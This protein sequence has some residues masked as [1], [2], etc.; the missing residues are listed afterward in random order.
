MYVM[1]NILNN[2]TRCFCSFIF[3]TYL[4]MNNQRCGWTPL[5]GMTLGWRV[6][7]TVVSGGTGASPLAFS[8]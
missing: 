4:R 1:K 7:D 6:V 5:E 8:L 3:L 2:Q